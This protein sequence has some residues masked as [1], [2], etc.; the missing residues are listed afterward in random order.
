MRPSTENWDL[1]PQAVMSIDE[2]I[3]RRHARRSRLLKRGIVAFNDRRSTLE[4]TIRDLSLTGCRISSESHPSIPD[5]FDLLIEL[6]GLWY[7]CEVAW[8]RATQVGL[9]FTGAAE[10]CRK[11]RIQVLKPSTVKARLRKA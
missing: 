6:D 8:R 4:G 1:P 11:T 7:P 2:H 10:Q 5:T 9:R 3:N